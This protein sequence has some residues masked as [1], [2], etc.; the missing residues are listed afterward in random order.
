MIQCVVASSNVM[1]VYTYG[2]KCAMCVDVWMHVYSYVGMYACMVVCMP[3]MHVC[4][5]V[6][7]YVMYVCVYVCHGSSEAAAGV[8]VYRHSEAR[9]RGSAEIARGV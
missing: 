5:Y 9:I 1:Y 6:C 4:T 2:C 7:L 3:A 8:C